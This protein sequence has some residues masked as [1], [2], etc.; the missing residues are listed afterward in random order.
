[1]DIE[2][3]IK[4]VV[5]LIVLLT[6]L[7]IVFI[8][9]ARAKKKKKAQAKKSVKKVVEEKEKVLP[10]DELRAIV[11]RKS[12]TTEELQKAVDQIVEHYSKIHPKMGIRSHPDFDKYVDLIVHLVRHRNTNKDLILKL[13]CA[14]VKNNPDYKAELN[15]TLTK[16]LNSRGI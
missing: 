5:G 11:R 12:S 16:A 7:V 15:D 2:L 1:M 9:P 3:I 14:L 6:L 4:S 10:F 8:L 13:D